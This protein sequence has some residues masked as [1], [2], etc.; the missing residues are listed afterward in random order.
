MKKNYI[1][2]KNY[3]VDCIS[4]QLDQHSLLHSYSPA[5]KSG[6]Y[7][8]FALSFRN[9]VVLSFCHN[10]DE[11]WIS[12]RPAGQ[13]WSILYEASLGWG[14]GCIRFWDRLDQNSG[15]HGK[16]KRPLVIMG[17]TMSP[18]FLCCQICFKLAGNE[19]RHKIADEF[20]FR[21]D[22]SRELWGLEDWNLVHTWAVSS[23]IIYTG[24]SL[25]LLI[26]L[27]I[28]SFFFLS[29]FQHWNSFVRLFSDT[30][31]PR[32]LK[33]G[34]HVDSGQMYRVYRNQAAVFYLYLYF[35]FF[36]CPIFKH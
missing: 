6:V 32:R 15:F 34:T 31:R 30:V 7:T 20:E 22:F 19:D 28:S 23:C 2:F 14:K 9:S 18:P 11:T 27:L 1:L 13:C 16:R 17:K 29:N 8:G 35:F 4:L 10:S 5:W 12:L 33:L 25:H 24:I 21:A 26:R 3:L 36:V